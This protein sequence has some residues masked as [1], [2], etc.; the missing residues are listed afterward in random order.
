MANI[1]NALSMILLMSRLAT[2]GYSIEKKSSEIERKIYGGDYVKI[3]D[4]PYQV[5][6]QRS[7]YVSE[8]NSKIIVNPCGGTIINNY[9][10]ATVARCIISEP[11]IR[12]I[13]WKY[14]VYLGIADLQDMDKSSTQVRKGVTSRCHPEF[15]DKSLLDDICFIGL[16]ERIQF[17]DKVKSVRLPNE[18]EEDKLVAANVTGF[19]RPEG[20]IGTDRKLRAATMF[21]TNHNHC[22]KFF[23]DDSN[24]WNFDPTTMICASVTSDGIISPCTGD[25]GSGLV[26]RDDRGQEVLLGIIHKW[27]IKSGQTACKPNAHFTKVSAYRKWIDTFINV[28]PVV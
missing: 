14:M 17:N 26:S 13:G 3:T 16:S 5:A 20:Y 15:D 8:N 7:L 24:W 23:G 6:I 21:I 2:D 27:P 12:H 22:N 9:W 25:Y 4:F 1:L 19:G 28:I 18:N 10:V 11:E